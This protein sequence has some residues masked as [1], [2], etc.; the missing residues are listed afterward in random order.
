MHR[1]RC[2]C[3]GERGYG[4]ERASGVVADVFKGRGAF[5]LAVLDLMCSR[6]N[7]QHH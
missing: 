7:T 5:H 1:F 6:T 4:D 2:V 3:L